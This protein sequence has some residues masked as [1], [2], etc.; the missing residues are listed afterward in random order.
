[1]SDAQQ[2]AVSRLTFSATLRQEPT[3]MALAQR[4]L[5]LISIIACTRRDTM[6]DLY[7]FPLYVAFSNIDHAPRYV[8][9]FALENG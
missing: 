8:G 3:F 6:H 4:L 7:A 9:T 2:V 5:K 1:M